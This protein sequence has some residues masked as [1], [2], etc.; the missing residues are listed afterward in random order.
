[1]GWINALNA[2][3]RKTKEWKEKTF[4]N[5]SDEKLDEMLKEDENYKK[6]KKMLEK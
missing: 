6:L 2:H 5:I 4:K 3:N 1:M